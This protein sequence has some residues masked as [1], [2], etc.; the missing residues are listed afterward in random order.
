MTRTHLMIDIE[1]LAR[2]SY[3]P[4][5]QLAA[6]KFTSAHISTDTFTTY[7]APTFEPPHIPDPDTLLWWFKQIR[8]NPSLPIP[9]SEDHAPT[10]PQAWSSFTGWL[11]A[12]TFDGTVWANDP[13]FDLAI[14]SSSLI[15][16]GLGPLPWHYSR[17]RSYRTIKALTPQHVLDEWK[18]VNNRTRNK[19]DAL[20]DAF[21]QASFLIVANSC[22]KSRGVDVL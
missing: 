6:V 18:A 1:T 19:H 12:S 22:L 15:T 21:E 3:A 16:H 2:H 7:I 5:I 17:E 13:S 9:L 4:I 20:D 11:G 8:A 14:L 10:F